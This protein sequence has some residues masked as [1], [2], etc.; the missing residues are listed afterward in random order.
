[1]PLVRISLMKGKPPAHIRAIADSVHRALVECFNTPV[2]DRFQLIYQH[3][4]DELIY[5][6]DYLGAHRTDD[7]VF[8]HIV[9][10]KTRDTATKQI[11]YKK[12]AEL[13]SASPGLR[14]EDVLVVL[15]PN[16]RDDWSFGN[17]LASYVK[18]PGIS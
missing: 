1:M 16:E 13:L 4:R 3:E 8:I 6:S 17:G 9:A 12:L 10:S 11:F 18:A 7:L 5:D 2:D 14:G 15:S